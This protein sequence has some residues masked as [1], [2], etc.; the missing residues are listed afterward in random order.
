MFS[1]IYKEATAMI[2]CSASPAES[3]CGWTSTCLLLP[4]G[5]YVV[6]DLMRGSICRAICVLVGSGDNYMALSP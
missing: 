5:L 2:I 6:W 3:S 4:L 1:S